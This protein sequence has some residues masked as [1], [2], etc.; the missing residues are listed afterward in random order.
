MLAD[1]EVSAKGIALGA[2]SADNMWQA[3]LTEVGHRGCLD[4]LLAVVEG[5]Y[6]D[7]GV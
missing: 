7:V 2:S 3:V 6:G 5:D 1:A 4:A